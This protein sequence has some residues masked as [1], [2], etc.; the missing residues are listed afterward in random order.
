MGF[1]LIS[2]AAIA[3]ACTLLPTRLPHGR[4]AATAAWALALVLGAALL[5]ERLPQAWAW[6]QAG[7]LTLGFGVIALLT[8]SYL[9]EPHPFAVLLR[10]FA[11]VLHRHLSRC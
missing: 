2:A 4:W 8:W 1:D 6:A 10:R 7:T 9:I 11:F 5:S 3:H